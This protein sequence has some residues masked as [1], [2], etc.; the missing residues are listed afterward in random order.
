VQSTAE[1]STG[2]N[3]TAVVKDVAIGTSGFAV[4]R[5][6]DICVGSQMTWAAAHTM[7]YLEAVATSTGIDMARITLV[8]VEAAATCTRRRRLLGSHSTAG[9]A[10]VK[11]SLVTTS[12]TGLSF[13]VTHQILATNKT[14][15]MAL[16]ALQQNAT[17]TG[18]SFSTALQSAAFGS[19]AAVGVT[20]VADAG[21]KL[22]QPP[23]P[24]PA[25]A[26]KEFPV[27][28]ICV[29]AIAAV[30]A[31][32]LIC[33]R[34]RQ[35]SSAAVAVAGEEPSKPSPAPAKAAP[36]VASV[37]ATA[38]AIVAPADDAPLIVAPAVLPPVA[39]DAPSVAEQ[40]R[41]C[42]EE[43]E[44]RV[45]GSCPD[46]FLDIAKKQIGLKDQ[47]QFQ[48]GNA[49]LKPESDGLMEQITTMVDALYL[50]LK[51]NGWPMFHLQLDGHVHPTGK[52]MRCLVISYFRAAEVCLRVQE[53][54]TPGEFLHPFAFGGTMPTGNNALDRRVELHILS[55][56]Q[57]PEAIA[58]GQELWD[59]ISGTQEFRELIADPNFVKKH[60]DSSM[61]KPEL[62][63]PPAASPVLT[64][65]H[66]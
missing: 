37:P 26:A 48:G 28:A 44:K 52:E 31:L 53:G 47:L 29:L 50:V 41:H 56:E 22:L 2:V 11:R 25:A 8:Q 61:T 17:A 33:K 60:G 6:T 30:S 57:V 58:Q 24:A 23:A 38:S 32:I 12:V 4:Q 3:K 19:F 59:Q 65:T 55:D 62:Y 35:S 21:T 16:L 49:K 10:A 15:G 34:C 27:W 43:V 13:S 39:A 66:V 36:A 18:A 63:M 46:V 5:I 14:E 51:E 54:G 64:I 40:L 20:S 42:A 45:G 1:T 9:A 7:D